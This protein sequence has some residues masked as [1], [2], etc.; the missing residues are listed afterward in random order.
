MVPRT[1]ARLDAERLIGGE[2]G[3]IEF[4]VRVECR[5]VEDELHHFQQ[6]VA[7]HIGVG[8]AVGREHD[9]ADANL[10]SIARPNNDTL[11]TL[12]QIAMLDLRDEPVVLDVPTSQY[13]CE[14]NDKQDANCPR[15]NLDGV[16]A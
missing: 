10:K 4:V 3:L 6:V 7:E 11:Y 15:Q 13:K 12:Y 8:L 2:H 1:V 5:V 9:L 16:I 14:G